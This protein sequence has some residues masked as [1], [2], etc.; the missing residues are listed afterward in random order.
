VF[1]KVGGA[2]TRVIHIVRPSYDPVYAIGAKASTS[3]A[4]H[5]PT[6]AID[7]FNNTYW[8]AVASDRSP[9]LTLTFAEPQD[10]AQ[11]GFDSGST[12]TAPADAFLAQP[13]PHTVHLVFSN[14]TATDLTLKDQDATKAQFYPVDAK[15][16]KFVEIHVTSV[17]APAG[18]SPSSVAI[19]EVEFRVKN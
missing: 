1:D 11:I 5:V 3:T 13:R 17:Y 14:G 18:A 6:L 19:S 10:L 9:T 7:K 8:A 4:G 15:Q 12:G 16:V 2:V